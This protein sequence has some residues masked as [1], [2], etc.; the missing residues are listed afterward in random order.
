[1]KIGI[2]GDL[3]LG[4]QPAKTGFGIYSKFKG[5]YQKIFERISPWMQSFDFVI[6][7]FEGVLVEKISTVSP[8]KSPMKTPVE[9]LKQLKLIKI[10]VL[11]IAN[12]HTMEYGPE[13][14]HKM[15]DLFDKNGF[16]T[17]GHKKKPYKIVACNNLNIGILGFSTIPAFYGNEPQYY[18]LDYSHE[19]NVAELLSHSNQAKAQCD[20]LI[21]LPH[22]GYEFIKIPSK[23]Q[24]ELAKKLTSLGADIIV[25]SHPHVIQKA[26]MIN[27]K[28]VLFSA[29]NFISDY[30][31]A[32]V[33]ENL[34][35]ELDAEYQD[36]LF[37]ELVIETDYTIT[38]TN[39]IRPFNKRIE[40][41]DSDKSS[42]KYINRER[43]RVRREVVFHLLVNWFELI[44]NYK[45]VFWMIRRLV[46]ILKHRKRLKRNPLQIYK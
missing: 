26:F 22:W 3:M 1:M 8:D 4:D 28:P 29:G 33:R 19:E 24:F 9:V 18:F 39:K 21:V 25:G 17:V 11:S 27:Q 20:Y 46:F 6:G 10:K 32:R 12:N 7:N 5:N 14:F 30:W 45:I 38:N 31:Q 34:L 23:Q 40:Y 35:V 42:L 2:V 13:K 41:L 15:C 36:F 16:I 44:K 43:N 37:H